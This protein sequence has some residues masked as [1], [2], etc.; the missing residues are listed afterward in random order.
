MIPLVRDVIC[1]PIVPG[2]MFQVSGSESMKTGRAPQY[3]TAFAVATNVREGT[4]TSSPG[5]TFI[6]TRAVCSATVPF[7]QEI[8]WRVL[9][10]LRKLDSNRSM[11][12]PLDEIQPDSRQSSTYSRSRPTSAGADT[13]MKRRAVTPELRIESIH[14]LRSTDNRRRGGIQLYMLLPSFPS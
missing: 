1:R 12:L 5:R 11:Y 4:S 2:S 7:V 13:G 10:N 8:E 3:M 9:Q 14:P 6:P